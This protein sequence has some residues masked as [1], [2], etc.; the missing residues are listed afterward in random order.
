M[1]KY[2]LPKIIVV[3]LF[4]G[5]MAIGRAD[6][7]N[8]S[9]GAM[10][11]ANGAASGDV[12]LQPTAS[13]QSAS[14]PAAAAASAK[15]NEIKDS[16]YDTRDVLFAGLMQLEA[17][18][19]GQVRELTARRA[20]MK[21][22]A[23]TKEWDFAMKEMNDARSYLR[24]VSDELRKAS[25]ETWNQQKETVGRAW[26]RTQAAYDAVKTSTTN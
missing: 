17:T 22:T 4:F 6:N 14:A 13:A 18:V 20:A 1:K 12:V 11:A 10:P 23:N 8:A 26:V 5:A 16:T 15:W 2:Q 24:S 9:D 7:G 25:V 19:D 21:S 3:A